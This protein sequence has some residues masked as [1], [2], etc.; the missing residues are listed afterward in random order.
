MI[1]LYDLPARE[2]CQHS[3]LEGC[4]WQEDIEIFYE[5]IWDEKPQCFS[6]C[7]F[8]KCL[9]LSSQHNEMLLFPSQAC[10]TKMATLAVHDFIH[11]LTEKLQHLLL[12]AFFFLEHLTLILWGGDLS[13]CHWIVT[14]PAACFVALNSS[15]RLP[16]G[17]VS[18]LYFIDLLR[19]RNVFYR[20][21]RR[22][23]SLCPTWGVPTLLCRKRS[24]A[25]HYPQHQPLAGGPHPSH[26][27]PH[28]VPSVAISVYSIG[29][30]SED[31]IGSFFNKPGRLACD[32]GFSE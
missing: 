22:R 1:N 9:S 17:C 8:G 28:L 3:A 13:V 12:S 25:P 24:L 14:F 20:R 32:E 26:T 11:A 19:C 10:V 7:K 5:N 21:L 15:T 18:R 30:L 27:R 31:F 16:L 23:C 2:D 29:T 4:N 6:L